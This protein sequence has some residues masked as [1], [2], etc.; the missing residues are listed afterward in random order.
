MSLTIVMV[1]HDLAAVAALCQQSVVL[2]Q[3]VVVEQ[4]ETAHVLGSPSHKYTQRLIESLPRIPI[5]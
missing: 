3:G 2:E 4:G 1:S 5:S